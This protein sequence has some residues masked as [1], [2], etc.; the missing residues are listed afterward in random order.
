M[1]QEF[2]LHI[3][4]LNIGLHVVEI[5]NNLKMNHLFRRSTVLEGIL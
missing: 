2:M 3:R 5:I 4:N 1:N